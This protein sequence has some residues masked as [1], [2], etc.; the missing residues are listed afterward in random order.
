MTKARLLLPTPNPS[1]MR[2][3]NWRDLRFNLACR[4]CQGLRVGQS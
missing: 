4:L 1:R 3:G 2:E